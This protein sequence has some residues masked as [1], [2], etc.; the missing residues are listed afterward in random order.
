M[1]AIGFGPDRMRTSVSMAK[2]SSHKVIMGKHYDQSSSFIFDWFFFILAGNEEYHK[3]LDGFEMGST[4]IRQKAYE[5][6]AL[7]HLEKSP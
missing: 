1:A 5:L 4:C 3:I 7:E 6:A 2:D